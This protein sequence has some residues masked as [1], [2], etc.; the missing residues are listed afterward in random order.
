MAII[1][2]RDLGSVGTITDT[3][4][5]NIPLNG[6]NRAFNVRFDEG[7]V[8]RAPVFR[9]VKDSLGFTPR[10]TFGIV[11]ATGFD[12]VVMVSDAYAIH[13]YASGT[14]TNRSGSISGSSDPRPLLAP[15]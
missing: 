15:H 13:E 9:K 14:T 6:F 2:V 4:P 3:S 12:T 11:P 7:S 10:F 5:Y 1:P 8:S